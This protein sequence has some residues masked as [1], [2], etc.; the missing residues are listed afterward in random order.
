MSCFPVPVPLR[1]RAVLALALFASTQLFAATAAAADAVAVNAGVTYQTMTGWEVTARAW[2]QDKVNNNYDPTARTYAPVVANR[3]VNEMGVNR[4]QI[5]VRSGYLNY[6]DYWTKFVNRQISYLEIKDHF[7]EKQAGAPY[8]YAEFDYN[9]ETWLL[10]MKQ[11]LEA[12]GEKLYV[13]LIGT[14]F[15]N[16]LAGNYEFA[17][18][19]TAYA[20]FIKAYADRLKNKYGVTLDAFELI[21]EPE[22]TTN[23]R[24]KQLGQAAVALRSMF[25]GAGYANVNLIAPSVTYAYNTLPYMTEIAKV[26]GALQALKTV[27]Y[28]RY[29]PGDFT[30]IGAYAKANGL[31]TAM[32]EWTNGTVDT[33]FD[34]LTLANVSS[35]QKWAIAGRGGPTTLQAAYVTADFT[36]PALPT[37]YLAPQSPAMA[38]FFKY[39]R[40]G[41]VRVGATSATVRSVA[42]VNT[43]GSQVVVSKRTSGTG[44][45]TFSGL[46]AGTYGVRAVATPTSK[47]V[48][49][50][51][52]VVGGTGSVTVTLPAGYSTLY[53]KGT[54]PPPPPA[55]ATL[56]EYRHASWNHYFVTG[57]A[58]EITKLDDGTFAGW[59]R[60]GRQFDAFAQGS[61]QGV[62]V[63]RF[64]STS[65]APRSSHFYTAF[66]PE[67]AALQNNADWALEGVVFNLAVPGESGECAAE[68]IPVY[69]LY[70]DGQNQVPNHRFVTGLDDRAQMV[71]AGWVAEGYGPLGVAMCAPI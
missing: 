66:A 31:Q 52:V 54:P 24:G 14:D 5:P 26:P 28:H 11:L 30:A 68:S 13:N 46:K 56:I 59:V 7:Y 55:R 2:E 27:A 3:L 45:V 12:K 42:F 25:E 63:C 40:L 60:T 41:A 39:V 64:F 6:V 19:P 4:L 23:W 29:N 20:N 21:L 8:Q 18:N 50:P 22:N 44:P 51:D 70:N 16:G 9:V 48:D 34:D 61:L 17:L 43:D 36:N 35:W 37:F 15:N 1:L 62:P 32:S 38:L 71:A 67:C 33:I 69:R 57:I 47:A 65:F 49:L 58:E 10:P 53:G